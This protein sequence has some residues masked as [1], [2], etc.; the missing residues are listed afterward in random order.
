MIRLG[1]GRGGTQR[2]WSLRSAERVGRRDLVARILR[3]HV[4]G[5]A[6]HNE[7]SPPPPSSGGS[8]G[9]PGEDGLGPHMIITSGLGKGGEVTQHAGLVPELETHRLV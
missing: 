4:L 1:R 5:K 2:R 6:A 9:R 3:L 8:L 7:E